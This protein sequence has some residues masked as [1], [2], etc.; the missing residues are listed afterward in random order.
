LGQPFKTKKTIL[1][2]GKLN[3]LLPASHLSN[4]Q[5]IPFQ[6]NWLHPT[7]SPTPNGEA[8]Y[9]KVIWNHESLN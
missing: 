8:K 2:D 1:K 3:L 4:E 9:I 5:D 7:I 6:P